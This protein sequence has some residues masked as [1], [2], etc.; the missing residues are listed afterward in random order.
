MKP[1]PMP[2]PAPRPALPEKK[3][4]QGSD[5]VAQQLARLYGESLFG[6]WL[7]PLD[8]AGAGQR[9]RR[10]G[11]WRRRL[12]IVLLLALVAAGGTRLYQRGVAQQADR[13]R[14][15]VAK[16]VAT[17]LADGELDRLAQ[18]LDI[19]LP[20]GQ[21]L[22]ATDP[23]LDLIVSA[24]AVLY[25]YQDAAP[26]RLA[27]IEPYLSSDKNHPARLL[28]RLTVASKPERAEAY[29]T[30]LA[31]VQPFAKDP[32][33]HSLMATLQEQR[34]DAK[35][36]RASWERSAQA[37]PLWLPHRYQ[38]CAFEAR[39][40]DAAAVARTTGHMARV[41]ADSAWTRLAYQHFART[42]PPPGGTSPAKPPSPVAQY[43]AELALVLQNLAA[44]DLS[45]SRPALGRA[46]AA[47]NAQSPFVLDAFAAL[48][49]AKA[50]DLA[51]ELSSYEAWPR[52][53]RWAQ[54]KLAELQTSV[55]ARKHP[56]DAT[57]ASSKA[58]TEPRKSKAKK[59]GAAKKKGGK[60][61]KHS[62]YRGK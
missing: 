47:V 59:G 8:S 40:H 37:G 46:L 22:Q 39:Q 53:N 34:G 42:T 12:G 50:E 38:Q 18:F 11:H 26:A 58:A 51:M 1:P 33:Y 6:A 13:E 32:E 2:P 48:L 41:A 49:D 17:F 31:M 30:L 44:R 57:P 20:P 7:D 24:E 5:R 35:A 36:A 9:E 19:L 61:R 28:A 29:D 45:A 25:R 43:Y 54:A 3:P 15:R 56:D 16:D 62:S 55:A 4:S 10:R 60:A 23:N 21:P 52:S 27:R 14:A